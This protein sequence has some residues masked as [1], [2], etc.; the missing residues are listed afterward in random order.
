ML[1]PKSQMLLRFY[2]VEGAMGI[3]LRTEISDEINCSCYF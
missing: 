2:M 1:Y 3:K